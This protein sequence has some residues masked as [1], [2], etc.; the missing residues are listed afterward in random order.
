MLNGPSKR[1]SLRLR[2]LDGPFNP[3]SSVFPNRVVWYRLYLYNVELHCHEKYCR[4]LIGEGRLHNITCSVIEQV[5]NKSLWSRIQPDQ[6]LSRL[7]RPNL[8]CSGLVVGRVLGDRAFGRLGLQSER[9]R[10]YFCINT[11]FRSIYGL[12]TP[13]TP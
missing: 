7:I 10:Q 5:R 11:C 6:A 3:L 4:N 9:S 1:L 8:T 12:E 2:R 13:K